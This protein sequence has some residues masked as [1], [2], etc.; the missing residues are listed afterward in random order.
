MKCLGCETHQTVALD[1]VWRPKTTAIHE[2][3]RYMPVSASSPW[4]SRPH[5]TLV[6]ELVTGRCHHS[7]IRPP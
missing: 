4:R 7:P 1:I 6:K 3:E 2:L 5:I